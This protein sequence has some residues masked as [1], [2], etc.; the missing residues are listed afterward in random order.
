MGAWVVIDITG[1][2]PGGVEERVFRMSNIAGDA[3]DTRD[4][5][6]GDDGERGRAADA[7]R[8]RAPPPQ[9]VCGT[10]GEDEAEGIE[11]GFVVAG[12]GAVV[13]AGKKDVPGGGQQRGHGQWAAPETGR[14]F[15]YFFKCSFGFCPGLVWD[16]SQQEQGDGGDAEGG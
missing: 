4:G 8:Q 5:H 12:L 10:E 6:G 1:E 15:G 14:G 13:P 11:D 7:K 9:E 2:A 16:E 3:E